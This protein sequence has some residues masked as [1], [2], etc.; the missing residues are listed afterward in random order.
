MQTNAGDLEERSVLSLQLFLRTQR[1][2]GLKL[3]RTSL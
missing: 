1:L 3:L 2:K